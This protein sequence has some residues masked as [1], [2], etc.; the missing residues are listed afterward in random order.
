MQN[1]YSNF[2]NVV[3]R[4]AKAL[5]ALG[6]GILML[7]TALAAEAPAP[8][9]T[10]D[11]SRLPEFTIQEVQKNAANGQYQ[12]GDRIPLSIE[13]K[14]DQADAGEA[15][16]LK[17]PDDNEKLEDLG[18]YI[19][20]STQSL[21]TSFR[22]LVS[23]I[24]TGRMTLP[25]LLIMK[26]DNI[27]I[28]KTTPYVIQVSGPTEKDAKEAELIDPSSIGL[29]AKYWVLFSAIGIAVL[30]LLF[31]GIRKFIKSRQK[32]GGISV[33]VRHRDP[34]HV[35]ALK[36]IEALYA[37]HAYSLENL[38]PVGFGVSEILKEFF[39]NRFKVEAL[40]S[41]TDEMVELLRKEAIS[42]ESLREIQLLFQDLDLVKF[43]KRENYSHFDEQ[44]YLDFKVK[45]N[46]IIQ[47]WALRQHSSEVKS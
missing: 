28:G 12:I 22:F 21:G 37:E 16:S 38:K 17:L 29:A 26:A 1:V 27:A 13:I 3:N 32:D 20:P 25:T 23:P 8:S 15:L 46:H 6:T 34:D 19:D 47:K 14:S 24:Q 30:G 42:G 11:I 18:W 41:T 31:Y 44:K 39:E 43:T 33:P 10:P 9:A 45:A 5:L 4:S 7:G 35:L 40:E 2:S 36:K